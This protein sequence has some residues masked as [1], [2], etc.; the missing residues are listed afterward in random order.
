L[1]DVDIEGVIPALI[2]PFTDDLKGI[3]EEGLRENVSR[4][5]EA[6]V[7][8]VV[9]AGTTGES[10]TLSHAEHRRVIEVVVD[11]VNGRVPV[12]AGAGS[13]STREALELSRYAE[14]VGA[15]AILSVVPYYNRPPQE[16]LYLH[17][18]RIAEAVDCPIILYN[19]PSRTGCSLDPE[20][21]AKLAEEYSNIVGVK[22]ASGNLDLVQRFV[23]ET[24]DDFIVLS[25]VDELNL[26]I[27]AVG[28]CGTVSVTANVAPELM[29]E[30]YEAWKRGD[31]ERARELHYRL[32]PLHRALFT[33]T[34]PI[35]VKAAAEMVGLSSSP[36]RPP[37]KEAREDTKELLR[38]V[39][40]DLG[41]LE[42]E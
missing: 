13:N 11:E 1:T 15:D 26:P 17:F 28:G 18:S 22:E 29:V 37:L 14:D 36:P 4:L 5:I 25:G 31:L 8:G 16:G 34:N 39:L 9:P 41:L 20:T 21:A 40:K 7:H 35:P 19:V 27:L 33:E 30:M 38:R 24:P 42:G 23:E 2:T 10:S 12:I 32:L 6:G 3:N